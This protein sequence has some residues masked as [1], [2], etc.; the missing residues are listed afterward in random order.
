MVDVSRTFTVRQPREVIVAYL[1]DFSHAEEW[2]PGTVECTQEDNAPIALGTRW[3][4]K[5]KL[6][7]IST[8]LTYELTRDDPDHVVFSGSNKTATTSDDLSFTDLGD[9]TTSVTY[10]ALVDFHRFK[11][12]GEPLFSFIFGRL[13]DSVPT[14]MTSVLE[15]L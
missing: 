13:A 5:S 1:R 8:E 10:R 7:G 2:D 14:Q 4:N 12:I 6:F 11:L 15:K 9:G 3:H